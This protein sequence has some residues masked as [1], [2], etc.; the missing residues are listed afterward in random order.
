M[1]KSHIVNALNSPLFG[2]WTREALVFRH[3]RELD[4]KGREA[5]LNEGNEVWGLMA[6]LFA[7]APNISTL[8]LC[9]DWFEMPLSNV[10]RGLSRM[11]NLVDLRFVMAGDITPLLGA[12]CKHIPE[13]PQLQHLS[14]QY[15]GTGSAYTSFIPP[16]EL[17]KN[18]P[19]PAF[20]KLSLKIGASS[21]IA[22]RYITWL[23]QPREGDEP[24][25]LK[26]LAVD[27]SSGH[28][29]ERPC[30][31]ALEPCLYD[32]EILWINA[33]G[34][35]DGILE[36]IL[37]GCQSLKR[38]TLVFRHNFVNAMAYVLPPSLE[39]FFLDFTFEDT[40]FAE[41]DSRVAA[42]IRNQAPTQLQRLVVRPMC[43]HRAGA[44]DDIFSESRNLAK[45]RG[46]NVVFQVKCTCR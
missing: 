46:L 16:S 32:L 14:L 38:L 42:F 9:T 28:Y 23:S 22:L 4:D 7:R 40:D 33:T 6:A 35:G 17:P 34:L 3:N 5:L 43:F 27:L 20:E 37:Q 11:S 8:S 1:R 2:K 21:P 25:R 41:W 36:R 18:G 24:F 15:S 10:V 13:M 12:V 44:V 29:S 31:E 45:E 39:E 19:R 26:S 30:I